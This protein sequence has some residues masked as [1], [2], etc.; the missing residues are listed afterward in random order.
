[1]KSFDVGLAVVEGMIE[2]VRTGEPIVEKSFAVGLAVVNTVCV[3]MVSLL[4]PSHQGTRYLY[5][6]SRVCFADIAQHSTSGEC[7][8]GVKD[9]RLRLFNVNR[10][11]SPMSVEP[12]TYNGIKDH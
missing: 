10:R 11:Q 2:V 5:R 7:N 9:L 8:S 1:M 3:T 4:A 6:S 12:K